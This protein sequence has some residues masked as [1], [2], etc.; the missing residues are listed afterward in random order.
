MSALE[1]V[2]LGGAEGGGGGGGGA[3]TVTVTE[4]VSVP[5]ALL[6]VSV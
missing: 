1:M 5:P 6:A 2:T 4:R 3:F